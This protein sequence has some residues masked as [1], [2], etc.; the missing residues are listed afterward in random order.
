[1]NEADKNALLWFKEQE[2]FR[3]EVVHPLI[4]DPLLRNFVVVWTTIPVSFG[5]KKS[6][7]ERVVAEKLMSTGNPKEEEN[8]RWKR[9][10][11]NVE[12]SR[13][14]LSIALRIDEMKVCRLV[15][16][17]IAFRL[18]YPDGTANEL[19]IKYIRA[20]ISKNLAKKSGPKKDQP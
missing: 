6:V 15:D 19:A 13:E 7:N 11:A 2:N 20:E 9:L 14:D 10:W 12:Y 3:S 4:R 18:I 16:R 8:L 1:M 5:E 17:A